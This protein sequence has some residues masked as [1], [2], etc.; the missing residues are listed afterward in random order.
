MKITDEAKV[1]IESA[2][3]EQNADSIALSIQETPHGYGLKMELVNKSENSR[4]VDVN[5]INVVMDMDTE[6]ALMT[7]S[8]DAVNGELTLVNE[9]GGC[10]SSGGCSGCS[11][12]H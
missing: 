9:G 5:G 4:V 11:G 12:C 1:V 8:F 10:C 7:T 2:L 3:K 6:M